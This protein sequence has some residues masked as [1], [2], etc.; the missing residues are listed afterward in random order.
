[1]EIEI[2]QKNLEEIGEAEAWSPPT[3]EE[4]LDREIPE[5]QFL[6]HG[7]IPQN[8]ITC[9]SGN[10]GSGKTWI[11]L[12]IALAVANGRK[13]LNRFETEKTKVLIVDEERRFY[14]TQRRLKKLLE[15]RT[16]DVFVSCLGGIK[17]DSKETRRKL[18]HFCLAKDIKFII[19]DS[20]RAVNSED[21]NNSKEAQGIIDAF[22]E[23][24]SKGISVLTTHHNRKENFLASKDP[25]QLFRGSTALL[26]GLTSLIS[27]DKAD[28]YGKRVE[29]TISHAKMNEGETQPPFQV[30]LQENEEEK[31]TWE[32]IREI[33]ME[34]SKIERAKEFIL[35][36]LEGEEGKYQ[37]EILN[38]LKTQGFAERTLRRGIEE[39]EKDEKIRHSKKPGEGNK[40]FYYL[41]N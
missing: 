15:P 6:V 31:I 17:I 38:T 37:V 4:L 12:E 29:L 1:M 21:E 20:L 10:P 35:T 36:I 16:K 40:K 25:T 11:L 2:L 32:F 33:E 26:A 5:A 3:F 19:F 7:L 13:F 30:A 34:Y 24:T 28:N 27:I 18:I 9:L 8:A 23:F 14:E 41:S 22:K 39:L